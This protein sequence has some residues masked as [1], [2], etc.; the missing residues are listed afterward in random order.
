MC[1]R[2]DLKNTEL[3]RANEFISLIILIIWCCCCFSFSLLIPFHF[4]IIA[5][6]SVSRLCIFFYANSVPPLLLHL[7]SAWVFVLA[8]NET[9]I[10]P[11]SQ[12]FKS[13]NNGNKRLV[14]IYRMCTHYVLHRRL[15]Q[16]DDR[17]VIIQQFVVVSFCEK[18]FMVRNMI[19]KCLVIRTLKHTHASY[20]WSDRLLI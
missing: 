6:L 13:T 15:H 20:T 14:Y 4:I 17:S 16:F 1:W 5:P 12:Y 7:L 9:H 18:W 2:Y 8:F 11:F 10:R 3:H 19:G